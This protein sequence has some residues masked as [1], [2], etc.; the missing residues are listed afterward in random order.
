MGKT[1]VKSYVLELEAGN[2]NINK[3]RSTDLGSLGINL[4][5]FCSKY[6]SVTSGASGRVSVTVY[7]YEDGTYSF[8]ID[9]IEEE[10]V[11]DNKPVNY[12]SPSS[13]SS[14]GAGSRGTTRS[15]SG[16][17]RT[18]NSNAK[19]PNKNASTGQ[20]TVGV[21]YSGVLSSVNDIINSINTTSSLQGNIKE[22]LTTSTSSI[23]DSIS[24]GG[25]YLNNVSSNLLYQI[26]LG[27]NNVGTMLDNFKITDANLAKIASGLNN[28]LK[29]GLFGSPSSTIS[30][31]KIQSFE[32]IVKSNTTL[33][34]DNI[35][36][37]KAGKIAVSELTSLIK[38]QTDS[39]NSEIS[40]AS[41][42]N[43][44]LSNLINSSDIQGSGWDA[45]KNILNKYKD[46]NE[47]RSNAAQTLLDAYE[48]AKNK[49]IEYI[50]PDEEMD[51]GE[52]PEY[53]E[54][55][56]KLK[57]EIA[58]CESKIASLKSEIA[59]L[60]SIQPK[61]IYTKAKN[62]KKSSKLDYSEYYSAQSKIASNNQLIADIQGLLDTA[63]S[64]KEEAEK[65]LERLK[66]LAAIISE[67]N[68]LIND[69]ITKVES[70]YASE[71]YGI[72]TPRLNSLRD[73]GTLPEE[74]KVPEVIEIPDNETQNT[75]YVPTIDPEQAQK[76]IKKYG[77]LGSRMV[78][79]I[80]NLV[81]AGNPQGLAVLDKYLVGTSS[82]G[83]LYIFDRTSGK[84]QKMYLG[85]DYHLGGIGYKDGNLYV[86]TN[87]SVTKYKFND[88]LNGNASGTSY[89][90]RTTTN[91]SKVPQVS[92]LTTTSDG[93]VITGQFHKAG[94]SK[95][96]RG[97]AASDLIVYNTDQ[98]GNLYESNTIKIPANM[99][100]IQGACVY[101]QN[102]KD[103]YLLTSSYGIADNKKS[104]LYV[105]TLNDYG[106]EL[107]YNKEYTLPSGA[108]QVT[109][110]NDGNIAVQYEGNKSRKN[111][112]VFNPTMII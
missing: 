49:I 97:G 81:T 46:C 55:I 88:L 41:K 1:V 87:D 18:Q 74:L 4:E 104:K 112:T 80:P 73:T 83:Y 90:S 40:D 108:E 37:G 105:A 82:D 68:K 38:K 98:N 17:T 13:G 69:A 48:E 110:T 59:R 107:V 32:S 92:F 51:D 7:V 93:R 109:V 67:A 30:T 62:G 111:I 9:S 29:Q 60:S 96:D 26:S 19:T 58:E 63:K 23:F 21:N 99:S 45:F 39:L 53:E 76:W 94:N 64:A 102:G 61:T 91:N 22:S 78:D 6:N 14:S 100:Q 34:D 56:E 54:T 47:T 95:Y 57:R 28:G 65:Y 11:A 16:S 84:N 77:D 24:S 86:A 70:M 66:G 31:D 25:N 71:V 20:K 101:N 36:I 89:K 44:S 35:S 5:E 10:K 79:E 50:S 52:I 43:T 72:N 85:K 42:M 2:A 27:M 75:T 15:T 33:F 3:L 8:G 103:Y 12:S 106:T